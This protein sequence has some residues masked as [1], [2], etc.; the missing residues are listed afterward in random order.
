MLFFVLMMRRPPRSTR[1]DTLFPYTTL[2]RSRGAHRPP[3]SSAR[4]RPRAEGVSQPSII[5]RDAT[6]AIMREV[7]PGD[8]SLAKIVSGLAVAHDDLRFRMILGDR[9]GGAR[10]NRRQA[11]Q[12][13]R[14]SRAERTRAG[15]KEK[16]MTAADRKSKR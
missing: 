15:V 14:T 11:P 4:H 13:R 2:F 12:A 10:C 16:I 8:R 9:K 7:R 5:E 1:T 6:V 3:R